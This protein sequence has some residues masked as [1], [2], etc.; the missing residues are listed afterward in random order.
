MGEGIGESLRERI[1]SLVSHRLDVARCFLEERGVGD[2][3]SVYRE[4]GQACLEHLS[5]WDADGHEE[6]AGTA[7][8]ADVPLLDLYAVSNLT[9]VRD[10]ASRD[11]HVGDSDEGAP[12]SWFPK[13]PM[14]HSYWGRHGI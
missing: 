2:A 5:R 6:L 10:I 1:R 9:D 13:S 7:R 12:P 4:A 14:R 11:R 3:L 8:A